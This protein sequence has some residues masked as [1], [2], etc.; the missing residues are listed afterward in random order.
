MIRKWTRERWIAV[1]AGLMLG[2][3]GCVPQGEADVEQQT[4]KVISVGVVQDGQLFGANDRISV[5]LQQ[6]IK[7]QLMSAVALA[8]VILRERTGMN[9]ELMLTEIG[10]ALVEETSLKVDVNLQGGLKVRERKA[11]APAAGAANSAVDVTEGLAML[12]N[13]GLPSG[14][15][16]LDAS[17]QTSYEMLSKTYN[18]SL[19]FEDR[20]N[21]ST[22]SVG[23]DGD[24]LRFSLKEPLRVEEKFAVN[25]RVKLTFDAIRAL[26]MNLALVV[27]RFF[28]A[29]SL[30]IDSGMAYSRASNLSTRMHY[31]KGADG[32]T[33]LMYDFVKDVVIPVCRSAAQRRQLNASVCDIAL[34]SVGNPLEDLEA[35]LRARVFKVAQCE[36]TAFREYLIPVYKVYFPVPKGGQTFLAKERVYLYRE[37]S[38]GWNRFGDAEVVGVADRKKCL[39]DANSNSECLV[40][41][42]RA[43]WFEAGCAEITAGLGSALGVYNEDKPHLVF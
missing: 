25:S 19:A 9:A 11:P 22:G 42:M 29:I 14:S 5:T 43:N 1:A 34:P 21:P 2:A 28:E 31:K 23:Q 6:E 30:S 41:K 32:T 4:T 38:G 8:G 40:A 35:R 16:P 26:P 20:Y 15:G 36:S 24:V 10:I 37:V 7:R 12:P 18:I 3:A 27:S 17:L 33:P 13:G 39:G